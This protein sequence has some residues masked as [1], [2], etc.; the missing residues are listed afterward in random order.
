[1]VLQ[2]RTQAQLRDESS[3][4]FGMDFELTMSLRKTC[5]ITSPSLDPGSSSRITT[6][7]IQQFPEV[8]KTS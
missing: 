4:L 5:R 7:Y 8:D 2:H 3:S 6:P 1:M